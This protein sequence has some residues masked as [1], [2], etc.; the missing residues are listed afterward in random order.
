M[1]TL[2]IILMKCVASCL[3]EWN[4]P[5]SGKLM[6]FINWTFLSFSCWK[7]QALFRSYMSVPKVKV[8]YEYQCGKNYVSFLQLLPSFNSGY[9]I[10][11]IYYSHNVLTIWNPNNWRDLGLALKHYFYFRSVIIQPQL[12]K[13]NVNLDTVED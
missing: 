11:T 4:N 9:L 6:H 7:R 1:A 10:S 2:Y 12:L 8:F 3:F 13:S 5:Y